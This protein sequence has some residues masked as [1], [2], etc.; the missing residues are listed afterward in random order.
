MFI[1]SS[2]ISLPDQVELGVNFSFFPF[3]Y[4]SFIFEYF[5]VNIFPSKHFTT[6][7]SFKNCFMLIEFTFVL[8]FH[9]MFCQFQN[10]HSKWCSSFYHGSKTTISTTTSKV[11]AFNTTA[12]L[13]YRLNNCLKVSHR[14]FSCIKEIV[15]YKTKKEGNLTQQKEPL[16]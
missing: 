15:I 8:P 3:P 4:L 6:T 1:C 5:L 12:I 7:V 16:H 11:T 10:H 13:Y 14:Y 2:P 9:I